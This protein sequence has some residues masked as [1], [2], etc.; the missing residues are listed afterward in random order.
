MYLK[1]YED[2]TKKIPRS[3]K[4][5]QQSSRIKN[6]HIK[7]SNFSIFQQQ[8]SYEKIQE[9]NPIHNSPAKYLGINLT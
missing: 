5:F 1:D 6:Q 3:D 7:I 8:T 4:H 9:N 2:S